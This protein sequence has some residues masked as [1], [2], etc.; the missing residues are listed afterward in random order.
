MDKYD[1]ENRD[2]DEQEKKDKRMT[3]LSDSED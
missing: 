2:E 1:D 3:A